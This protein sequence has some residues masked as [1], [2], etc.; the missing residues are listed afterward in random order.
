[1]RSSRRW[2]R[3]TIWKR[4]PTRITM[5]WW[6]KITWRVSSRS[7]ESTL[8]Y[9]LNLSP[10]HGLL[11]GGRCEFTC[12]KRLH[13]VFCN[14]ISSKCECE[15]NYPVKLGRSSVSLFVRFHFKVSL[16]NLFNPQKVP[17]KAVQNVSWTLECRF[18]SKCNNFMCLL[19][20]PA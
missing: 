7:L 5:T 4:I 2:T 18:E 8:S 15:K 20:S 16:Y 3:R 14:P 17:A 11:V 19:M 10:G 9:W 1:M 13:H 12:D 6:R